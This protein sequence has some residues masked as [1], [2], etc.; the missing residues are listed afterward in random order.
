M[1]GTSQYSGPSPSTLPSAVRKVDMRMRS[2]TRAAT[3]ISLIASPEAKG[4]DSASSVPFS[5]TM[6]WPANTT[7]VVDSP[8]PALVYT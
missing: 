4:A 7:S 2:A 6:S 1:N 5:A 3:S 8:H